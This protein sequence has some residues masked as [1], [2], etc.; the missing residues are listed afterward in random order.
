MTDH[1]GGS[2]DGG[3]DGKGRVDGDGEGRVDE[4]DSDEG[5]V[6]GLVAA[7]AERA[8]S[9]RDDG[10]DGSAAPSAA[11]TRFPSVTPVSDETHASGSRDW[12]DEYGVY[13]TRIADAPAAETGPLAGLAVAVKD[14]VAVAGVT[15]QLGLDGLDWAPTRDATVVRR[16]R[17]AGATLRGTTRMDAAAMGATG[18][19]SARGRTE[20]PEAPGHVPGGS[21][22]G[23]AAAVAA[24]AVDAAVGTDTGGSVRVPAAFCGV[25]GIKPTVD[26]VPRTGVADLAPT[27]D[28]VGV[29]AS[30][31]AT[32]ARVLR[33]VSGADPRRPTTAGATP[34]GP[35][36]DLDPADLAVVVPES[37]LAVA[38]PGVTDRFEATLSRLGEHGV[39]VDR[40]PFPEHADAE[41]ANQLHTLPEF[42]AVVDGRVPGGTAA[43]TPSLR[44]ALAAFPERRFPERV[45]R[46]LAIGRGLRAEA[47]ESY[48]AAWRFRERLTERTRRLLADADALVTPTAP[49]PP[50]RFGA[51][52]DGD[53]TPYTVSD[54][55]AN[56]AP[57]DCT[58]QPAVTVPAGRVD[59]QPVGVQVVTEAGTD[60]RALAV[61]RVLESVVS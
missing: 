31:V 38:E 21:S 27:L 49:T 52:G 36:P 17:A 57:F 6:S 33:E 54:L 3:G 26:R 46:L 56:T 41:F 28:H 10:G 61:A 51:V 12:T 5:D 60:E 11:T 20:N 9:L 32:T 48:A 47:P 25:V 23:S 7:L 42:A 16:L 43:Q 19:S 50:L 53:D 30:D 14:N 40:E 1:G 55:L 35:L 37:V 2:G 29:L 58:G 18:E 13:A 22:S 15:H 4:S 24:G 44:A 8:A 39:T 59:G 34:L 45:R